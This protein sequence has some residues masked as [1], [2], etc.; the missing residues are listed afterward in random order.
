MYILSNLKIKQMAL[1]DLRHS[2]LHVEQQMWVQ[3]FVL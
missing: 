3:H 1:P 2:A